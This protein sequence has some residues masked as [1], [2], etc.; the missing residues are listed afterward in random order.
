MLAPLLIIGGALGALGSNGYPA[1]DPGLW[2]MVGMAGDDGR[3]DALAADRHVFHARTDR[4]IST[5]CRPCSVGS[6]A[7]HGRHRAADEALDPH[8]KAGAA[9]THITREYSVDLFELMRVGDVMDRDVFISLR[10][11]RCRNIQRGSR[12]VTR[13]FAH[14]RE[15]LLAMKMA[16]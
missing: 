7:A 14:I 15:L 9:R 2:A 3:D 8:R 16:I 12:A 13:W 6:V 10:T 11:R 1:G 5:P 4:T